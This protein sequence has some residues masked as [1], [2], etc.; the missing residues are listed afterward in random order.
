MRAFRTLAGASALLLAVALA[1]PALAGVVNP[2]ISVIGQ[3]VASWTDAPNDPARKRVALD[4]GET[5]LAF[6]SALNPFARGLIIVSLANGQANIEEAYFTMDRGLPAGLVLK[7]GKYRVGFGKLNPAHPHAYPF[8]DRFHVLAAYL[9]GDDSFD[10]TGVQLSERL[11][12]PGD[13]ALTASVDALQGD[14][15]R[16]ARTAGALNDPLRGALADRAGEPRTAALGRLSA[17]VPVGDRSGL[18]LGTSATQ[19]TNNVAAAART[20]LLGG[21]AKLKLW[22]GDTSN[23]LVQ[24]EVLRLARDEAGWDSTAIA[25]TTRR[26]TP[27]GGY[28]FANYTWRTRWN[29][30]MS[31][32]RYRTTDVLPVTNQA[33]GAFAGLALMEETTL[34]RLSVERL[35]PGRAAGGASS[36]SSVNTVRLGVIYS[37]GPHKAHQF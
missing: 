36:P 25:Y 11:P 10:E 2:D 3:P 30:G 18:E 27:T 9:P 21:D 32:E 29:A 37:M 16:I 6:D 1:P 17:F 15:F 23:L 14:S 19:G 12:A 28:L 22:T 8:N 26:I 7:G 20:T 5:E 34:F 13:I 4:V 33:V 24:G 31:Y 35:L